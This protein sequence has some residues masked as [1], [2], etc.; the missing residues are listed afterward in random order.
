MRGDREGNCNLQCGE[1][2]LTQDI[3][4]RP[5]GLDE[6][7]SGTGIETTSRVIEA[8]NVG[9]GRHHFG[10]TDTF[11]FASRDST[12]ELIAHVGVGGVRDVEHLEKHVLDLVVEFLFAETGETTL[13]TGA[14]RREREIQRLSN[15]EGSNV[16]IV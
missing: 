16:D 6:I 3:G 1:G 4:H 5:H 8:Q 15:I 9:P 12:N 11:S 2:S 14:F 7:K 13:R 10:N